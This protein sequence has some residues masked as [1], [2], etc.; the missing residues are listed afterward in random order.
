MNKRK[1]TLLSTG[2]AA[3]ALLAAPQA[4]VAQEATYS[5]KIPAQDL[6]GALR[7]YA[8]ITRQQLVFDNALVAGRPSPAVMGTLT[9]DAALARL[10]AGSG[11]SSNRTPAGVIYV[12][13]GAAAAIPAAAAARAVASEAEP[14]PASVT[15]VIVTGSRVA[16]GAT[17][18]TPTTVLGTEDLSRVAPQTVAN[19]INLLPGVRATLT[20]KSTSNE[21]SGSAGN[22]LDLRGLGASRTLVL[23]NGQRF[24]P[25]RVSG[26]VDIDVIPQALIEGVDIVTGGASAV[27]GSDAVSGV[28]NL[29]FTDDLQG[30]KAVAQ[31]GVSR[32]GDEE[33]FLVSGAYGTKFAAG[34]GQLLLGAEIANNEGFSLD[35][36]FDRDWA[37]PRYNLIL[38]PAY[39]ATN[40][41]PQQLQVP[42]AYPS[43]LAPGGLINAGPLRGTQFGP[44]GAPVPFQYGSLVTAT[45][46]Q[47]GQPGLVTATEPESPSRRRSALARVSF[48]LT[49]T[50]TAFAE[51]D[52][53]ETRSKFRNLPFT[54]TDTALTIR[55]DNAFLP[56]LVR[57]AMAA[58]GL[59]SFTMGRSNFDYATGAFDLEREVKRGVV[60][61]EG[62]FGE[63]WTW[64]AYFTEGETYNDFQVGNTRIPGRFNLAVDAVVN[65]ATG[66]AVCRSTLTDPTNGCVPINLF[67]PGSVSPQAAAY[68]S[69][70]L[71]TITT[72][73]Q[74]AG[75][76]SL[77]GEP[78][79]TWAGP[80]R[81][82]VGGEFRRETAKVESD[83]ISSVGG[84]WFGNLRPWRGRVNVKEGF[85]EALIPLAR[86]QAW[87]I[88]LDLNVAGRV[89]D[90]STSGTVTTWKI[91]GTWDLNRSVRFRAARSRDIRAPSLT[92]L[93]STGAQ[94]S[95]PVFDPV[96]GA[97]A[98]VRVI[99]RG[100]PDLRPEKADTWTAGVVLRPEFVPGL[101]VSLDYFD[102]T[103]NGA[104]NTLPFDQI[105]SG[106]YSG[107]DALC[108]LL[109]RE[110]GVLTTVA[111]S[112]IN[113]DSLKT[114]GADLE[115]IYR[116]GEM[117]GGE[118][119]L[120][121][122]ASYTDT[123]VVRS[124]L[125][126]RKEY[127]GSITQPTIASIG[128][129]PHWK[130]NATAT[131]ERDRLALSVT[132]RYVGGGV[133][134]TTFT[135]K[136][137]NVLEVD[138]RLYTDVS[139][140][141]ELPAGPSRSVEVF[142]VINNL[143]DR[144]PPIAVVGGFPTARALYDY[145]GR[146][147]TAGVR[148]RF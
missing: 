78:I 29:R 129:Q 40:S 11:L 27:Y 4:V 47:G 146:T 53:A 138:G 136:S 8:R 48:D 113:L 54:P 137:R 73:T 5:F 89:T 14:A 13:N 79:S 93:F 121:G 20:P 85:A 41:E 22:F 145:V 65:P 3:L 107:Q 69:G 98:T 144:A 122:L 34:R 142:G 135:A 64:D 9:A 37:A 125:S 91:G 111:A 127:A 33:N 36:L 103:V 87:A 76:A 56:Q 99:T 51:F 82:A 58:Q 6:G 59:T 143:F 119:T 114:S 15:E 102:I 108:T 67:G 77:R 35:E 80:V 116:A 19:A 104:L 26:G 139:A 30:F 110:N 106:C 126:G 44:G 130:A 16:S 50:V 75:A 96:T 7:A 60:G 46:M 84:F 68:V 52:Y 31:A 131:Y 45:T 32:Y 38:N 140:S 21:A 97:L 147:Y 10:L 25:A 49:D 92:E 118:L 63:G 133:I 74:R 28:V 2:A 66:A 120:R 43:N 132:E 141:Y 123:L 18:P 81:V 112:P 55:A 57:A 94:T 72:I 1:I 105:V 39:T 117:F 71:Q 88:A 124:P 115:V 61:L 134:D 62:R 24:V 95:F 101:T 83:P 86:D 23:V 100:N 128:G 42:F 17:A 90:Y 109:T 148:L 12:G 70:T